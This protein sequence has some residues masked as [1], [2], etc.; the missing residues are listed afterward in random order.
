MSSMFLLNKVSKGGIVL[1]IMMKLSNS[2]FAAFIN[3]IRSAL[4]SIEDYAFP[5]P[6]PDLT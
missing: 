3:I 1:P 4:V 6:S 2:D 5:H